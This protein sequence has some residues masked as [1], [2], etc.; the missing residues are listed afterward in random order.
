MA[1]KEEKEKE[2]SDVLHRVYGS[3]TLSFYSGCERER[4]MLYLASLPLSEREHTEVRMELTRVT[5]GHPT[6]ARSLHF[7]TK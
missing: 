6:V 2:L 5:G 7:E 4:L 3:S 1:R